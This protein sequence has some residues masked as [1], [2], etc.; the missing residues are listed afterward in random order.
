MDY[1][2]LLADMGKNDEAVTQYNLYI[3][4]YPSDARAYKNVAIV[5]KRMNNIDSAITNYEKV[6][7]LKADDV[8]VKKDLASCY[9]AKKDYLSALKYYDEVLKVNPQ[10]LDVKINKAI[11]FHALNNY[12]D[13]IV[14][15]QEVLK[16]KDNPTVSKNLVNAYVSQGHLDVKSGEYSKAAEYFQKAIAKD[17]ANDYAYYGL[18]K[19][20]QG[21]Q[22]NDEAGE[23]Y[24]KAI[25]LRPD[26]ALYSDEYG[27]FISALYSQQTTDSQAQV[28]DLPEILITENA[29]TSESVLDMQ[30]NKD[31][32]AIGDEN[33]KNKDYDVAV[34]N[35][36]NAL[37]I[38]PNDE[39]TLLK[40]GNIYKMK[41]DN[42][43]ASDFYKKAIIVN[44]EYSDG[45]F[46]LGLVYANENNIPDA[47]KAFNRVV[48]INPEYAY[49]YFALAIAAET[50]NNK[51]EAL[52]N[53]KEFLKY[54]KD[55]ANVAQVQEKIKKLEK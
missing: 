55:A 50:E 15:Y 7:T 22:M 47:K 51:E 16:I 23:M 46:N 38:N 40:I 13:A 30:K 10:D 31:L 24:E 52:K 36:Q 53:Y 11:A 6:L 26:K 9:H 18:A 12:E 54:N 37:K 41:N 5:Y 48:E 17:T 14:L 19:A 44:P 27:E 43:N 45:W 3:K 20:Y 42:K 29:E 2:N 33:Y 35:Y 8:D 49:A 21:L 1:A 28:E 39:V 4:N 32:I 25:A 34:M